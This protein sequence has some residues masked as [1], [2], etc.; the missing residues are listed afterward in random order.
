MIVLSLGCCFSFW[1]YWNHTLRE[2]TAKMEGH[3]QLGNYNAVVVEE[4][5]QDVQLDEL[6]GYLGQFGTVR[7]IV[8]VVNR[9][10]VVAVGK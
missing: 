2:K 7:E 6:Q 10:E 5:P 9:G 8:E 3:E 1:L 4:I